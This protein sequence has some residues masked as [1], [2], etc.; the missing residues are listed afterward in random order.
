LLNS[1]HT[2]RIHYKWPTIQTGIQRK[3]ANNTPNSVSVFTYTVKLPQ[4]VIQ[5]LNTG[6]SNNLL[7]QTNIPSFSAS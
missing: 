3:L 7:I 1:Q 6:T 2:I 5:A 4:K